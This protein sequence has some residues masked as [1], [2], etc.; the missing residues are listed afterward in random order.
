MVDATF[1]FV[2]LF[3]GAL[4]GVVTGIVRRHAW[5]RGIVEV[6]VG[7]LSGLAGTALWAA[8]AGRL[9]PLLIEAPERLTP[10]AAVLLADIYYLSPIIGGFIG[11]GALALVYRW[12]LG[13]KRS[14]PWLAGLGDALTI[15]GIVYLVLSAALTAALIAMAAYHQR[16]DVLTPGPL[17]TD[18]AY[19]AAIVL[20]GWIIRS[21]ALKR[22]AI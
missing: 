9:V 4:V 15:V 6:V 10:R 19:G 22:R 16:W 5:R 1:L 3:G 13:Q 21:T 11:V 12:G 17:V 7:F 14:E 2:L 8:I 18:I 20:L